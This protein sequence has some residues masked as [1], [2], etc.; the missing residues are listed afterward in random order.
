MP[1]GML[2]PGTVVGLAPILASQK[3]YSLAGANK[4]LTSILKEIKFLGIDAIK[5]TVPDVT[6]TSPYYRNFSLRDEGYKYISIYNEEDIIAALQFDAK[7]E[8]TYE[9]S[10]PLKYI[11]DNINNGTLKYDI[12]INARDRR[13]PGVQFFYDR[14][15]GQ[16]FIAFPELYSATN[17]EGEYTLA[18]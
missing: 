3:E 12:T 14:R 9:L 11:K 15:D 1:P 6:P 5:D 7:K 4:Q 17:V 10:I 2:P 16:S 18:K 8:L 13:R